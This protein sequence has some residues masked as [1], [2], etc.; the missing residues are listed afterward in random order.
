MDSISN[1]QSPLLIIKIRDGFLYRIGY[2]PMFKMTA[3]EVN[4]K[5]DELEMSAEE[6][7]ESVE[8]AEEP[9]EIAEEPAA[10]AAK[11]AAEKQVAK[12]SKGTDKQKREKA[13]SKKQ[14]GFVAYMKKADPIAMTCFVAI[15]LAFAVVIGAWVNDEYFASESSGTASSGSTVEVEYVGSYLCYYDENGAVIFDTNIEDAANNTSNIF[16]SS[17]TAKDSYSLLSFTIGGTQVI[18]AFGDACA[19]HSVG[20]VVKVEVPASDD[21]YGKIDRTENVDMFVTIDTNGSMGLDMYNALC[22]TSYT[23]SNFVPVSPIEEVDFFADCD[24]D[25]VNYVFPT[26]AAGDYKMVSGAEI[27][28][29]D[30]A[31]GSFKLT[32]KSD[33][34]AVLRGVIPDADGNMQTAYIEHKS[35]ETTMSYWISDCTSHAEQKGETM[36]FYIKIKSISN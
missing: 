8:A 2:A 1:F 5:D 20:D 6:I 9:V 33:A 14:N 16:S 12:P 19:G 15:I 30:V 24:G 10:V 3:E 21:A 27:T 25:T 13:K 31:G 29:S 18:K 36:F 4:Q 11:P 35:G 22:G 28:V 23:A 17:F 7:E 32:Y 34:N 26:I